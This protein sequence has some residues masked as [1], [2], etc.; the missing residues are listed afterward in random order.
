MV[1]LSERSLDS[2]K[3][4]GWEMMNNVIKTGGGGNQHSP[5]PLRVECVCLLFSLYIYVRISKWWNC[6]YC[7]FL[8]CFTYTLF[9]LLRQEIAYIRVPMFFS[10]V[11]FIVFSCCFYFSINRVRIVAPVVRRRIVAGID[12]NDGWGSCW[13]RDDWEQ[14]DD[15]AGDR[16]SDPCLRDASDSLRSCLL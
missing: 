13:R 10:Y 6:I 12:D 2:M 8:F 7:A 14:P 1:G 11:C 15:W 9:V 5:M 3:K 16:T 4:K